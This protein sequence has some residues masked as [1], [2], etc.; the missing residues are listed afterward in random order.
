MKLKSIMCVARSEKNEITNISPAPRAIC[1]LDAVG[2]STIYGCG[3]YFSTTPFIVKSVDSGATWQYINMSSYA[4]GLVEIMFIDENLGYVSGRS[5]TGGIVL[6]TTDGGQNWVEIYNSGIPGEYVWKMQLL[7][8][9][10][11]VIFGSIESVTPNNGKLIRTTNA[12]LTWETKNAP[13]VE[14]QAVGFISLDHGWMGGHSTGF[15][16]TNDGG[17]TWVNLNVGSN[18]NRIFIINENLAYASGT[19]VYKYDQTLSSTDFQEVPRVPLLVKVV[20][21]PI[22]DK[23]NLSINFKDSDNLNIELY[24]HLGRKLKDL[25]FEEI[26]QQGEKLYSFDFPYPKGVYFVNLHSNT[27]RQSIKIIK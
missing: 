24:D 2:T 23:L 10:S 25:F 1:G 26:T 11:D 7:Q 27:G 14:I 20:P 13:E 3:A 8:G 12:G 5:A 15:Y 17:N 21:N 9:N 18:L 4:T 22:V 16:E 6:K 19:T